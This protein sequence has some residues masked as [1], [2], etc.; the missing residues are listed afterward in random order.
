MNTSAVD[1]GTAQMPLLRR[2]PLVIA[3]AVSL[4]AVVL[5]LP[6]LVLA[7]LIIGGVG[8]ALAATAADER[9]ARRATLACS[10]GF[11]LTV[12]PV[13][14]LLLAVAVTLF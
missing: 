9:T 3:A 4:A 5:F 10:I 1:A 12:G 8:V 11:G 2:R 13:V 14:Y 7:A 6:F